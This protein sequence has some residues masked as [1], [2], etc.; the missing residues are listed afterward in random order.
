M[1]F[2]IINNGA[3]YGSKPTITITGNSTILAVAEVNLLADNTISDIRLRNAGAG[4]RGGRCPW[5][6][7]RGFGQMYGSWIRWNRYGLNVTHV[8]KYGNN[9]NI[10]YVRD[11]RYGKMCRAN[12]R[13]QYI[14]GSGRYVDV[15]KPWW[16][17]GGFLRARSGAGRGDWQ[18]GERA[19]RERNGSGRGR[20]WGEGGRE[21]QKRVFMGF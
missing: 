15:R 4:Y 3:G 6:P 11:G 18:T 8:A 16:W 2:T 12:D 19:G 10:L 14:W 21:S 1:L 9:S 20:V 5:R 13:G 17:G 7:P